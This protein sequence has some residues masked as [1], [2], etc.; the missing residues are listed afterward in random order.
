MS[1]QA[2]GLEVPELGVWMDG[3]GWNPASCTLKVDWQGHVAQGK[4]GG[5][6]MRSQGGES[7][8]DSC[9]VTSQALCHGGP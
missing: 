3:G 8:R 4:R 6:L 7:G 2:W 1:V 9:S 5:W